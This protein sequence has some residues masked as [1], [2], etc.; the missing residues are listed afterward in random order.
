MADQTDQAWCL[1]VLTN[2]VIAWTTEYYS[3]AV[4]QPRATGRDIPDELLA[5]ISLGAQREPSASSA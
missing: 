5:R 3:L 4:R 2:S 1:T